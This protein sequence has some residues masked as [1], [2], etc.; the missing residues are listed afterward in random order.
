MKIRSIKSAFYNE[1]VFPSSKSAMAVIP[2][3]DGIP[4]IVIN[5]SI[6]KQNMTLDQT[7]ALFKKAPSTLCN[8]FHDAIYHEVGH[9]LVENWSIKLPRSETQSLKF[10]KIH[11]S[12]QSEENGDELI[13]EAFVAKLNN[14][15]IDG[16]KWSKI[17]KIVLK[18]TGVKL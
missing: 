9:V 12:D 17:K 18:F 11:I 13:A 6:I 1:N 4:H 5:R 15:Q 14:I 2:T 8:S 7:N 16:E 3:A 10:I